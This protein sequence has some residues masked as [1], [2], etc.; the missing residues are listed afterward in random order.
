MD[1]D[2][3]PFPRWD[4]V[5]EKPRRLFAVPFSGRPLGGGFPLLASRSCPEFCTYCPHRVLSPYRSRSVKNVADE[6]E[7][8]CD[9]NRRPYV[10]FRDPLFSHDRA[11]CEALCDEI[12]AR[13]LK[14]RFEC[15]TRLDRL[16]P[17]L[18]D[19]LH[20]AGL[21]TV[22]FGVE[23]VSPDILRRV[24]RRPTPQGHQRQIIEHCHRRGIVT[25]GF[26][27]LG[28]LDDD[29][30]SIS[31]TIDYAIDLGSTYAQFKLLTPYPATPLWKKMSPLVTETDWQRF[32]GFTPVF[33]H[34]RLTS[35][36]MTRLLG[37]AYT[38]FYVRPSYVATYLRIRNT[39]VLGVVGRLDRAVSD[40][41]LRD[42]SAFEE[43]MVGTC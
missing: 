26:Y 41:H 25:A 43:S 40:H 7:A 15:E 34:P 42:E 30:G 23:S 4:P 20:A 33:A 21:R 12:A 39:R 28:F 19:R 27:V 2:S 11:R 13:D 8:L 5:T 17:D 1:L 35:R 9:A 38:R 24:G 22:S 6:L 37:S 29:R 32:D 31:A 16:D 18:I 14:L 3:L 10:I 36:D